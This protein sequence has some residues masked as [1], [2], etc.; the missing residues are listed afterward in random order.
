M[1]AQDFLVHMR[2]ASPSHG[3]STATEGECIGVRSRKLVSDAG[4]ATSL[5]TVS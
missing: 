2:E 1:I 5:F 4:Y 3:G